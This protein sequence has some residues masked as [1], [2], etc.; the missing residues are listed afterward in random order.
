MISVVLN[1]TTIYIKM[2]FIWQLNAPETENVITEFKKLLK[3]IFKYY[4]YLYLQ[5]LALKVWA[6]LDRSRSWRKGIS[7]L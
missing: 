7:C 3:Y 1:F 5:S 4:Y 6:T 2:C